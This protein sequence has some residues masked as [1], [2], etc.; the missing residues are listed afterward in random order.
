MSCLENDCLLYLVCSTLPAFGMSE[1]RD[2]CS[3]YDGYFCEK[4]QHLEVI[5]IASQDSRLICGR[6][7]KSPLKYINKL[8]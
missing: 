8:K 2:L 6:D 7:P 3:I 4:S 5:T 1:S